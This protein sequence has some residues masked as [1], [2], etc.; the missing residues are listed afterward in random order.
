MA[1]VGLKKPLWDTEVNYG[2]RR[3]PANQVV[4]EAEEGSHLRLAHIPRLRALRDRPY[5]LVRL[6][7]QRSGITMSNPDGSPPG[8][9][10]RS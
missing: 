2:D 8:P 4:L 5:V 10:R 7:H 6:G 3:N 9:A 1:K